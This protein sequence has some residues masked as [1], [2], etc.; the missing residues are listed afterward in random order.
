[1]LRPELS[2]MAVTVS[3]VGAVLFLRFSDLVNLCYAN[4][5]KGKL[6][7]IF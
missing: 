6:L 5:N 7:F 2:C 4:A 3:A 1:M